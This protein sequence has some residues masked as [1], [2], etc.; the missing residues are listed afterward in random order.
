MARAYQLIGYDDA[1]ADK[2]GVDGVDAPQ[3][4]ILKMHKEAVQAANSGVQRSDLAEAL[5]LIGK[6]RDDAL[7]MRLARSGDTFL[8]VEDAYQALSAPQ[9]CIDDGLIM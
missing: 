3:D 9:D 2:I 6:D 4:Y 7:M 8:S 1:H 5:K